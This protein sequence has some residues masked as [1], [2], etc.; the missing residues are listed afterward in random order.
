[1]RCGDAIP[2]LGY[3]DIHGPAA[4]LSQSLK[5]GLIFRI[6]AFDWVWGVHGVKTFLTL[7]AV[8]VVSLSVSPLTGDT[9]DTT[10]VK[11]PF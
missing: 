2:A 9:F 6:T 3:G 1:M 11:T 7:R 5:R 8:S 4:L 10:T